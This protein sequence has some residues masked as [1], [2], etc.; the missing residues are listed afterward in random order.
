MIPFSKTLKKPVRVIEAML[1]LVEVVLDPGS[2]A[3]WSKYRER[4]EGG[5]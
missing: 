4:A 2:S 1:V 3:A 5:K